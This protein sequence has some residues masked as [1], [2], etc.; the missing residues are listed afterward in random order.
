MFQRKMKQS[1]KLDHHEGS[2]R[3]KQQRTKSEQTFEEIWG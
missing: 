1:K 2:I 3:T